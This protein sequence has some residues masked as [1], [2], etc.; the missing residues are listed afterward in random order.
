MSDCLRAYEVTIK[1]KKDDSLASEKATKIKARCRKCFNCQMTKRRNDITR[2]VDEAKFWKYS[3]MITLT[4]D[5][6]HIRLIN[7]VDEIINKYKFDTNNELSKKLKQAQLIIKYIRDYQND[8]DKK[9]DKNSVLKK[10]LYYT[11]VNKYSTLSYKDATK[12]LNTTKHAINRDKTIDKQD[13]KFA[14]Y[15][16]GEYPIITENRGRPH[17][18]ILM[19]FNDLKLIK[20]FINSW[21]Y[22]NI[23]IKKGDNQIRED[24]TIIHIF[25]RKYGLTNADYLNC[26]C[27]QDTKKQDI[28]RIYNYI[29]D[30]KLILETDKNNNLAQVRY[31]AGYTNK[32]AEALF[33]QS[34][35]TYNNEITEYYTIKELFKDIDYKDI[36]RIMKHKR[37]LL[38]E[39]RKNGISP[40]EKEEPFVF[41]SSG[42]GKRHALKN[43]KR[44]IENPSEPSPTRLNISRRSIIPDYYIRKIIES[45]LKEKNNKN[46]REAR[47]ILYNKNKIVSS[48]REEQ[49]QRYKRD[50]K[51][52]NV[53]IKRYFDNTIDI[54]DKTDLNKAGRN[55]LSLEQQKIKHDETNRETKNR[56]FG[57][58]YKK[59]DTFYTDIDMIKNNKDIENFDLIEIIINNLK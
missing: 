40:N 43:K 7:F 15:G 57:I 17:Y 44:Y 22:G 23:T 31:I 11:L 20:H 19:L 12:Y 46:I 52:L 21:Y 10:N 16:C 18:H 8:N 48:L 6:K 32:K 35:K 3:L 36:R 54:I 24:L 13:K 1:R 38:L 45:E 41:K 27:K 53:E 14:Y 50:Y 30:K 5:N 4:Y 33:I 34:Q 58:K 25:A 49:I 26:I 59:S 29:K 39:R 56:L 37:L 28:E 47:Y 55:L 51:N 2:V 9:T 42:L